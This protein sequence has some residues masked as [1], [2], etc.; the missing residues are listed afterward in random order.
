MICWD[1]LGYAYTQAHAK[2]NNAK[3]YV[4]RISQAGLNFLTHKVL[5]AF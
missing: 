2:L 1:A 5:P 4:R 3:N